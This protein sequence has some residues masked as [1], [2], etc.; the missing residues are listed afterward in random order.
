MNWQVFKL[1]CCAI[2]GLIIVSCYCVNAL[3][4]LIQMGWVINNNNNKVLIKVH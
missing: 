2:P 4:F 1:T 3:S